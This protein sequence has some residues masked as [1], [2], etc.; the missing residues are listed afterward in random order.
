M[1]ESIHV[2]NR[3]RKF[4]CDLALAADQPVL[5]GAGDEDDNISRGGSFLS[6]LKHTVVKSRCCAA[7]AINYFAAIQTR[8]IGRCGFVG[9]DA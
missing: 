7:L 4:L 1:R 3:E 9:F 8:Q 5:I 2:A 6:L